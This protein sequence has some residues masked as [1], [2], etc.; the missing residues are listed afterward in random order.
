LFGS[1]GV[2]S[3]SQKMLRVIQ[4]ET[5]HQFDLSGLPFKGREEAPV[6]IAVFSDYQ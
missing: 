6:T 4:L 5:I 1:I 2:P 3:R